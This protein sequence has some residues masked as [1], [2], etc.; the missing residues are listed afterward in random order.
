MQSRRLFLLSTLLAVGAQA[1]W[2]NHP[3]PR[4]PRTKDGK[5]NLAANASRGANGKPDLSGVWQVKPTPDDIDHMLSAFGDYTALI[6]PGDDP[7]T[8]HK[9]F[10]NILADF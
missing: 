3:S 7:R 8:F 6:V 4:T 9:Y 1:Q 5:A 2:L 10:M